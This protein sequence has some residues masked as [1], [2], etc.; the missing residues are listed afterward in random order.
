MLVAQLCA[1]AAA[2]GDDL[3]SA[4]DL[5]WQHPVVLAELRQMMAVLA[6]QIDHEHVPLAA[7]GDCPLQVHARY[8]RI[9]IQAAL[10]DGDGDGARVPDW[11]E[12]VRWL[13][14]ERSDALLVTLN[15]TGGSFSPTTAY[16]DYAL[17]RS[18]FHWESQSTTS[19]DSPTGLRYRNHA[20]QG[21]RVLLFARM[22]QS[23]RDYWFLGEATY[24]SHEGTRPMAVVWQLR[25]PIPAD[26]YPDF[27]AVGAA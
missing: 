5:L 16:R 27:A 2:K 23:E 26:L 10:G 9:E 19:A 12:G 21:S 1:Q 6:E 20:A 18:L 4:T 14:A 3:A 22:E 13:P 24:R 17:T 8:S 15:K 11:R 7:A 25:H